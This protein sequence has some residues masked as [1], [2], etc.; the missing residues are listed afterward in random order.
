MLL[1]FS[2]ADATGVSVLVRARC[3]GAAFAESGMHCTLLHCFK[4]RE[5]PK[6]CVW[7]S[8]RYSSA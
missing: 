6:L 1:F 4:K 3:V 2:R 7:V 5:D 8:S